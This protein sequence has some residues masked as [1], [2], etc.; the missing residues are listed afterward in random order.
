MSS[1][2]VMCCCSRAKGKGIVRDDGFGGG[3]SKDVSG[4]FCGGPGRHRRRRGSR[5]ELGDNEGGSAKLLDGMFSRH[6]L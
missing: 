6:A 1:M 2:A 4:G 3:A 5:K